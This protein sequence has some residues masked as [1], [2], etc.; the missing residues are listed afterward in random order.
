MAWSVEA[1]L[2]RLIANE[3]AIRFRVD[4]FKYLFKRLSVI[5]NKIEFSINLAGVD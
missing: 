3:F 1:S 4:E 5:W 2:Q